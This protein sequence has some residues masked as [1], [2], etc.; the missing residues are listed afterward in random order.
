MLKRLLLM[1]AIG[2]IAL[3]VG[4]QNTVS[5]TKHA[6][7]KKTDR[8]M[9]L[10]GTY[11]GTVDGQDCW[12]T[13]SEKGARGFAKDN[14]WQVAKLSTD[15]YP[16]SR[17]DLPLTHRCQLLAATMQ[18]TRA[19][20]L[21]VD[22]SDNRTTLVFGAQIDMDSLSLL[23]FDTVARYNYGKK[24]RCLIWGASS[25]DGLSLGL[26]TIMQYAQNQQYSSMAKV[27]NNELK[28]I[29]SRE[30]PVNSVDN[31]YVT[32]RGEMLTLG[33]EREGANELIFISVLTARTADSFKNT[34]KCDP[35][36]SLDILTVKGRHMLCGGLFRPQRTTLDGRVAGG[37]VTMSFHLDSLGMTGF[38]M[39]PFQNED[40]NILLNKS[41]KRVQRDAEVPS[42]TRLGYTQTPY[43]MLMAFG[44][45]QL[46]RSVSANGATEVEYRAQGMHLLAVDTT[47]EV[48]WV[49]NLRRNDVSEDGQIM[50]VVLFADGNDVCLLKTEGRKMPEK[51][52]ISREAK[53]Y[54]VGSKGNLVLYRLNAEGD[55][56]KAILE[57]KTKH[58]LASVARREDGTLL[59][60]TL[61]GNRSRLMEMRME[62]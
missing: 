21:L 41:T 60:M 57:K 32:D 8:E 14:D 27:Y 29:W 59:L 15:L 31:I 36:T 28:E 55:V 9:V 5:L 22:S 43:G 6:D 42:V 4:A 56:D 30:H 10:N 58:M 18:G 26:L 7:G 50:P 37:V 40:K 53:E 52:E 39:R 46:K 2:G 44:R 3:G 1:A 13:H 25:D 12:L 33:R 49:R 62:N 17:L 16:L 24:D 61:N 54:E 20:V 47:G 35:L 51:Y 11:L 23:S 45:R 38:S 48:M 34:I 19:T